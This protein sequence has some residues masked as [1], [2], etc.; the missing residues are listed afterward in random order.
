LYFELAVGL[1]SAIHR[2]L[3]L[4][5]KN[6]RWEGSWS[7]TPRFQR[8]DEARQNVSESAS[9]QGNGEWLLCEALM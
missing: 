2:V 1:G 8:A 7:L 5:V 6:V 4:I 3:I 9:L